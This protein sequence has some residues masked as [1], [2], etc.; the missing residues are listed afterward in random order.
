MLTSWN[1]NQYTVLQQLHQHFSK[2]ASLQFH[3]PSEGLKIRYAQPSTLRGTVEWVSTY[4]LSNNNKWRWCLRMVAANRR[5]DSP[6]RLVWSEGWRPLGTQSA[7][8]NW[9][10]WTLAMTMSLWQHHKHCRG[11]YYYYY[12]IINQHNYSHLKNS[13]DGKTNGT[14]LFSGISSSSKLI[15]FSG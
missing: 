6:N 2:P 7:F 4:E 15:F 14:I 9:T 5:T 11:Y 3:V 1:Q 8:I 13:S 10:G 12:M